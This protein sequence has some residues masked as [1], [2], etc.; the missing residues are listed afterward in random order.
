MKHTPW[1]KSSLVVTLMGAACL[2]TSCFEPSVSGR[3]VIADA[4]NIL[5]FA[6]FEALVDDPAIEVIGA[7]SGDDGPD[8]TFTIEGDRATL[9]AALVE[10]GFTLPLQEVKEENDNAFLVP[11]EV[12][13]VNVTKLEVGSFDFR[14][15]GLESQIRSAVLVQ[16]E[17][18]RTLLHVRAYE[19]YSNSAD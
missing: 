9:Q 12:W 4:E 2:L 7:T 6:G 18:G 1:R 3:H 15:G 16:T 13:V 5:S 14:E 8:V 19:E 17:D 10:A 11:D